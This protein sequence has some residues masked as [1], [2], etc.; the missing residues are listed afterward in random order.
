MLVTGASSLPAATLEHAFAA[1]HWF[2]SRTVTG[3]LPIANGLIVTR[4]TG[5]SETSSLLPIANEFPGMGIISGV[6]NAG[7]G[8][9]G[10]ELTF[11]VSIWAGAVGFDGGALGVAVAGPWLGFDGDCGVTVAGAS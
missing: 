8:V 3:N 1:T 6:G 10:V 4:W 11:G 9:G 5:F 7:T 2:H